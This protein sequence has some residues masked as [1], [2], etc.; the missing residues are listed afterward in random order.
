MKR[1]WIWGDKRI[2]YAV[3]ATGKKKYPWRS[4]VWY[5]HK[6]Y[7]TDEFRTKEEAVD[8]ATHRKRGHYGGMSHKRALE[9]YKPKKGK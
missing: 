5:G 1:Q 6:I 9:R 7:R 3:S 2:G 4:E 8:Y